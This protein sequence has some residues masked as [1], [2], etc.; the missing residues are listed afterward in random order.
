MQRLLADALHGPCDAERRD[1]LPAMVA[2][3]RR[4]AAQTELELLVVERVAARAHGRELAARLLRA[5]DRL[6]C[7]RQQTGGDDLLD[8]FGVRMREQ[9]LAFAA[10]VGGHAR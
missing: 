2:Y 1:H 8:D 7:T 3:R 9:H 10:A 5:D 6:R 4:R